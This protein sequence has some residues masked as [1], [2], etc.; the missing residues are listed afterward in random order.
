MTLEA[1]LV[2]RTEWNNGG[3]VSFLAFLIDETI[4]FRSST[5]FSPPMPHQ[6]VEGLFQQADHLGS[7]P[8]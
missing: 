4:L 7:L 5:I 6:L 8:F 1:A 2:F 3:Q